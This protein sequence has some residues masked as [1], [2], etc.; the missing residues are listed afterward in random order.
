MFSRAEADAIAALAPRGAVFEAT[1]FNASRATVLNASLEKY[2]IVHF[3]THGVFDAERPALSSLVLSLVNERGAPQDGYFR[4]QDAYNLHLGADLVVLS[5]CETALG[6]EINGEGL[7]G[8]ARAFMYAGAPRVVASLWP[9]NDYATA[10]LMKRFYRGMLQQH[11]AP[12]AALSAAQR[13]M[14]ANARWR[15]PFFWAG[16]TFI[17]D[18]R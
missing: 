15:S 5:A 4:M 13:Q 11:L 17:G 6:K 2:R 14:R 7:V 1:D 10:E 9:V 16:I 3:A 8:L 12:A 18:W